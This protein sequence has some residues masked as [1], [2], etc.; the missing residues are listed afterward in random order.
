MGLFDVNMPPLYQ[1]SEKAFRRLWLEI[2]GASADESLFAWDDYRALPLLDH[3]CSLLALSPSVFRE[4]GDL[5]RSDFDVDGPPFSM[6][7]KGLR[8]ELFLVPTIVRRELH[9]SSP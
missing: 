2:L 7:N 6:T 9:A 3:E 4:A 8:M 1:E 5:I